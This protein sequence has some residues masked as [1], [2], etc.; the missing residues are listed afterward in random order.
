VFEL[1]RGTK[2]KVLSA[3]LV[4]GL[5]AL[6]VPAAGF[7]VIPDNP[8]GSIAANLAAD[9]EGRFT[10][11]LAAAT[12]AGLDDEL[13]DCSFGPVTLFAPT[14]AAFAA[15]PDGTLDALLADPAALAEVL[16]YHLLPGVV[17]A[18]DL[19]ASGSSVELTTVQGKTIT[20]AVS[21][22]GVSINGV[23]MVIET[24]YDA[25]NGVI[26]V[27]DAVLVPP[28]DEEPECQTIAEIAAADGRFT[29]LLAAAGIAG[30]DD[31]LADKDFGPV[32]VFAP[33]DAAFAALK[34][35]L[36]DEAW[37]ALLADPDTLADVLLYH[38]V[39]GKVYAA[40][41]LGFAEPT[42]VK[43]LLGQDI[44]IEVTDDG[45]VINGVALVIQ[46]DIE[47]C[48]GVIHVI[49]AVLVP[50]LGEEPVAEDEPTDETPGLPRT[51]F[52][53]EGSLT[54]PL[55]VMLASLAA[56]L[57]YTTRRRNA[58]ARK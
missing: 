52:G 44:V 14:N 58:T 37:D 3:L 33:T 38:I 41:V 56:G 1:L 16:K 57:M 40:D 49:D 45:V 5:F 28:A 23:A 15:L 4:A 9:T 24:D 46:T 48:N 31:E 27:I 18:A 35:A 10:T 20:I 6:M 8:E 36:G 34:E 22:S 42:P 25:C 53:P 47:A 39:S 55:A 54:A 50:E 7:A 51:G 29:T 30:L 43:T 13:A 11:L 12:A 19:P 2:R 26:H 32:T 21:A 17:K